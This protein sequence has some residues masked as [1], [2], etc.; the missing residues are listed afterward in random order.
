M[1]RPMSVIILALMVGFLLVSGAY[2]TLR[3]RALHDLETTVRALQI[4]HADLLR[5]YTLKLEETHGRLD[6]LERVLFG[7]IVAKVYSVHPGTP[8]AKPV[9]GKVETWMLNQNKLMD[10]RID[11]LE[12]WRLSQGKE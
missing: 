4:E 3:L 6:T 8:A 1:L 12:A 5:G 9:F 7:D 2:I 10:E 11:R